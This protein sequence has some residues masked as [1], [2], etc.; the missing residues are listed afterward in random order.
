MGQKARG[1]ASGLVS[2]PGSPK[3]ELRESASIHLRPSVFHS[4][5]ASGLQGNEAEL[6]SND[7]L[8]PGAAVSDR[9]AR[10]PG[11]PKR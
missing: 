9:R 2:L 8:L 1:A 5:H 3:R 10:L 6:W 11:S 4:A 7:D